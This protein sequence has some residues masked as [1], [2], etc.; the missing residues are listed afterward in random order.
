MDIILYGTGKYFENYMACYG[1]DR[2]PLFA[3]DSDESKWGTEKLGVAIKTPQEVLKLVPYTYYVIICMA[4][5]QSAIDTLKGMN[6]TD[7]QRYYKIPI[8][9][10]QILTLEDG[11]MQPASETAHYKVGYVPGVFD[12]FHAGHLNLLRNAKSRCEYLIAGVLTDELIYHFKKK[13]PIIPY[14]QRAAIIA[15]VRYVDR[16]VPVDFENTRKI[17][18]W[19]RMHYDCHFSGDDHGTDWT[20]DAAQLKEVGAR[21]EFFKYSTCNSTTN[22]R[23]QLQ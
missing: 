16:V 12:M 1:V 8:E 17:D 18:A 14:A 23:K 11:V 13:K 22:I 10:R 7:Y 5:A 19:H 21:M 20:V 4:D 9:Q 6:V 15:D 2:K 3:I